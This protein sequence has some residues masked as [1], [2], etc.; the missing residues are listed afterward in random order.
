M[1]VTLAFLIGVPVVFGAGLLF[2][3]GVGLVV[4]AMLDDL[5]K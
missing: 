4:D 3:F 1:A 5:S 2:W